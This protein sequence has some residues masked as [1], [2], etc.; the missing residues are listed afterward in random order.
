MPSRSLAIVTLL[1]MRNTMSHRR[2]VGAHIRRDVMT[3]WWKIVKSISSC[4]NVLEYKGYFVRESS[5][6]H[7][8][9][10][11]EEYSYRFASRTEHLPRRLMRGE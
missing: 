6:V 9:N 7:G 10:R 5:C 3:G 2:C 1:A 11:W 4:N 8:L